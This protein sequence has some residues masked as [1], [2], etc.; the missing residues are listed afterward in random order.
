VGMCMTLYVSRISYIL[1]LLE[2][3]QNRSRIDEQ[4]RASLSLLF[5]SQLCAHASPGTRA[6]KKARGSR[7]GSGSI[8]LGSAR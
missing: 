2:R 5:G 6:G 1:L 8:R 3:F 7:A 4:D